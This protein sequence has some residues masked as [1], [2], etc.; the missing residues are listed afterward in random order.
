MSKK[1]VINPG[2]GEMRP[3]KDFIKPIIETRRVITGFR[4]GEHE[5]EESGKRHRIIEKICKEYPQITEHQLDYHGQFAY[6]EYHTD[7]TLMLYAPF[8]PTSKRQSAKRHSA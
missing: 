8:S 1:V 5:P 4:V 3:E 2:R 6:D 7:I